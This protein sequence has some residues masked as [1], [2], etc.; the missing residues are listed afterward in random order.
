M[1]VLK[2]VG[3]KIFG[4]YDPTA[5]LVEK[6]IYSVDTENNTLHIYLLFADKEELRLEQDKNE[7]ILGVKNESRKVPVPREFAGLDI[8]SAKFADGYLNIRFEDMQ[9]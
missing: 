7:L 4:E 5:V 1:E 6:E 8:A 2:D 9:S 3:S